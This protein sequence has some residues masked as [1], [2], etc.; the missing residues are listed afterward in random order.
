[1]ASSSL[2]LVL[3]AGDLGT[4]V[5]HRLARCGF[6]VV[7]GE[8]PQPT[9]VRRAV[10]F[11]SAV[12][13]GCVQVEAIRA[14][15]ARDLSTAERLLRGGVL[16]VMI[17]TD[18]SLADLLGPQVIVDARMAKRNLGISRADAPLVIGLGPG[19]VAGKD[20][21]AVIETQ[22][23]HHLGCVILQ[24]AAKPNSGI[25]GAVQGH[26]SDRVLRAPR[27]GTLRSA[28][29]IG[30]LVVE[31]QHVGYVEGTT[32]EAPISGVVRGLAH[33]GLTV[34]KGQKVGDIDPRGIRE[35]CFTISDKARAVA[36]G[37]LEAILVLQR[38]LTTPD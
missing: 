18:Q 25:P 30:G 34:E 29:A 32:I 27:R 8:L 6:P 22:R 21:N 20:V 16:P 12:Y 33:D 10:A 9:V 17:A 35:H 4:G 14:A 38:I 3:G 1:M 11:A 13:E 24:G 15:L 23:G 37:V 36:G 26:T 31:G 28:A 5:A 2:V 7:L 19:F